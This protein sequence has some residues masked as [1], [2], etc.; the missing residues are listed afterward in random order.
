[1]VRESEVLIYICMYI[2]SAIFFMQYVLIVGVMHRNIY[3][4]YVSNSRYQKLICC[5]QPLILLCTQM[6]TRICRNVEL[7]IKLWS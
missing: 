7:T 1:M 2:K 5:R 4:I 6:Y 3:N